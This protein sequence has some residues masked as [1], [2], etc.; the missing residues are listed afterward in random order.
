MIIKNMNILIKYLE[1]EL[2]PIYMRYLLNKKIDIFI[3]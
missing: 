2:F 3:Y 1:S